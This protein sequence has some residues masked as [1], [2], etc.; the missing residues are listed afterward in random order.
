MIASALLAAEHCL[1]D[2]RSVGQVREA[3]VVNGDTS[4]R[5]GCGSAQIEAPSETLDVGAQGTFAVLDSTPS[6][7]VEAKCSRRA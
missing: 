5:K 1:R 7:M 4:G 2:F 6:S 3:S